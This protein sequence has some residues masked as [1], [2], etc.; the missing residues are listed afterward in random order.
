MRQKGAGVVIFFV[1]FSLA[2][3]KKQKFEPPDTTYKVTW[4]TVEEKL[5]KNP[6]FVPCNDY[7]LQHGMVCGMN[8]E[9]VTARICWM[10]LETNDLKYLVSRTDSGCSTFEPGG[11]LRGRYNSG[12]GVLEITYPTSLPKCEYCTETKTG[13]LVTEYWKIQETAKRSD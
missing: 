3:A 7:M 9:F 4:E 8:S 5:V 11:T 2:Y 10:R 13:K 1:L 6:S 12:K